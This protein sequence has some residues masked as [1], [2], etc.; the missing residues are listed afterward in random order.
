MSIRILIAD[1]HTILRAGLRALLNAEPEFQV[2]GEAADG[3][4]A[5]VMATELRPDVVVADLNMP[6]A[7]GIDV[8]HELRTQL[9]QTRVLILTMYEDSSLV[10]RALEAGASGYIT[11]RA[12]DSE[13]IHAVRALAEGNVYLQA[14]VYG[15]LLFDS[16]RNAGIRPRGAG[17]TSLNERERKLLNLLASGYTNRQAGDVLGVDLQTVIAWRTEL[18]EKLGL[19][20]RVEL[21]NYARDIGVL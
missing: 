19:H 8:A 17:E 13:L 7:S 10:R 1:D 14:G 18:T 21:L 6:K 16:G 11:K 5:V 12:A 15:S 4:Q 9:P 20:S 3:A 2:I